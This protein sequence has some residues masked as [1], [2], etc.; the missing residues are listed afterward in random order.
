MRTLKYLLSITTLGFVLI[1]FNA[2]AQ[3][4]KSGE[5]LKKVSKTYKS[6]KTVKAGFTIEIKSKQSSRKSVQKGTIF[7]KGKRFKVDMA[8]QEIYCDGKTV[9][10]YLEGANEVQI[11]KFDESQ[12]EVSPSN[13]F[14][15]YEKGFLHKFTGT[16]LEGGVKYSKI[17][18]T[19][20]DKKKPFFKVKLKI[21]ER[22]NKIS[23]M[24]ILAKNGTTTTYKITSFEGNLPINDSFFK[25]DPK[26]KPGVTEIDLR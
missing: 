25:F 7:I 20:V 21:D 4:N 18:L 5:I 2:Y 1:F 9:W 16:S 6:Y 8:G 14:T 11:S 13:I 12:M 23:S 10:T 19:P 15:I 24:K 22:N 17:E 3:G 26:R